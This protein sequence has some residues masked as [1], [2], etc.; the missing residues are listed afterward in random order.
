[1]SAS[2]K[3]STDADQGIAELIRLDPA[4]H[5]ATCGVIRTKDAK[6][7]VGPKPNVL[8]RRVFSHYRSCQRQ[9]KACKII[10]LK[11]RQTGASTV[12]QHLMYYHMRKYPG[13]NAAI[14]GDIAGTS[15]KVFDLYRRF[16]EDDPFKWTSSPHPVP[17]NLADEIALDNGSMYTKTTAGSKNAGRSGT[18]Q[19]GNLTEPAFY[20][21]Q[22]GTDPT[23]AFLNSAYDGG[24]EC[25]YTADST[26]NGPQGWFYR[27][28]MASLEGTTDWHLVFAAWFEFED[29]RRAFNSEAEKDSFIETLS[30]DEKTEMSKYQC[31]L[32]QMHWRRFTIADKCDGEVAKFRQEYP[33]DIHE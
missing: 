30:P 7:V 31:D 15:D 21:T 11:P 29:H 8:Q 26:P 18:I 17:V 23:L 2:P 28:C 12:D 19:A 5:F 1:M 4:V 3:P 10:I 32:E 16:A 22:G 24:P 14:M 9:R 6:T 13:T 27:T 20:A 25:L 33:S